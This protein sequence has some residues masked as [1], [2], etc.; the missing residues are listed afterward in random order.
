MG[1]RTARSPR[2]APTSMGGTQRDQE[3]YPRE[4]RA[5]VSAEQTSSLSAERSLGAHGGS[6]SRRTGSTGL[7]GQAGASAPRAAVSSEFLPG[8]V[9]G[10]SHGDGLAVDASQGRSAL[11]PDSCVFLKDTSGSGQGD[12]PSLP[13]EEALD[14]HRSHGWQEP[15]SPDGG[16]GPGASAGAWGPRRVGCLQGHPPKAG[17]RGWVP[18]LC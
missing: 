15:L 8:V 14:G 2:A 18:L 3:G 5:S 6:V 11:P 17:C 10:G 9:G 7:Y 13:R 12:W 1:V 16:P 4:P